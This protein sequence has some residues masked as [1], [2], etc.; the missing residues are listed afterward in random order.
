MKASNA[1]D[2]RSTMPPS[3]ASSEVEDAGALAAV[4]AAAASWFDR[5]VFAEPGFDASAYVDKMS[6][7][8]SARVDPVYA[9]S[10]SPP[11]VRA[12]DAVSPALSPAPTDGSGRRASGSSPVAARGRAPIPARH[13]SSRRQREDL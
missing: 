7:Y 3:S 13:A 10:P 1:D 11:T 9:R 4:E 8:V 12:V 5:K 2:T 6:P